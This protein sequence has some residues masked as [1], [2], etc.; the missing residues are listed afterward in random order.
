[1]MRH[2]VGMT[3]TSTTPSDGSS[4]R[5]MTEGVPEHTFRTRNSQPKQSS[6]NVPEPAGMTFPA[7]MGV[8][9]LRGG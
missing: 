3:L 8:L 5:R 2:G 7:C 6:D 1:M 4:A 9:C